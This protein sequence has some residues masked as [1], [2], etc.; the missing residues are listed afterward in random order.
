M[1]SLLL[2]FVGSLCCGGGLVFGAIGLGA[3]YSALGLARYIPEALA[4]GAILIAASTAIAAP[5]AVPR[6]GAHLSG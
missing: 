1:V 2:G 6:Y 5:C 4:G 3:F